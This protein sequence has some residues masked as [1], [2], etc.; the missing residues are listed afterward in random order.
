M[1]KAFP[2]RKF[3]VAHSGGYQV[4]KYFFH[5]KEFA[6]VGFDLSFSLQYLSDTSCR[7]DLLKLIRH[8]PNE[9]IF[10]GSDYPEANP[11]LQANVLNTLANELELQQAARD[12]MFMENWELFLG[13]KKEV[14]V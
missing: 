1:I 7:A 10:F 9:R 12:G 2:N 3:V 4:L 5:L 6:N 14:S 8:I 13:L 11:A